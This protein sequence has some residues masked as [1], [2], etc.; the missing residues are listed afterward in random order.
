M[1]ALIWLALCAFVAVTRADDRRW[2]PLLAFKKSI[3]NPSSET[4]IIAGADGAK[5][6]SGKPGRPGPKG[7]KGNKAKFCLHKACKIPNLMMIGFEKIYDDVELMKKTL[8]RLDELDTKTVTKEEL[9]KIIVDQNKKIVDDHD[10]INKL[11]KEIEKLKDKLKHSGGTLKIIDELKKKIK[12]QIKITKEKDKKIKELNHKCLMINN[13]MKENKHLKKKI[14]TLKDEIR[15][16][17]KLLKETG[18]SVKSLKKLHKMV[19]DLHKK[20][21]QKTNKLNDEIQRLKNKLRAKGYKN[22][23]LTAQLKNLEARLHR[24]RK[25]CN[26][27]NK[28]NHKLVGKYNKLVTTCNKNSHKQFKIMQKLHN[29]FYALKR[30]CQNINYFKKR[31]QNLEAKIKQLVNKNNGKK[32]KFS[33]TSVLCSGNSHKPITSVPLN[34]IKYFNKYKKGNIELP[35]ATAT[36]GTPNWIVLLNRKDGSVNFHRNFHDYVTGFGNQNGEFWLGLRAANILTSAHHFKLRVELED[37]KGRKYYANYKKFR[38]GPGNGYRL[39]I[40]GFSGNIYNALRYH[41][42]QRFSTYDKDQDATSRR[43]CAIHN[44]G[45]WYKRCHY[46]V[47]TGHWHAKWMNDKNGLRW[48]ARRRSHM[49]NSY[50]SWKKARML[51]KPVYT[52]G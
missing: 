23:Q 11:D 28:R 32:P 25:T 42:N 52:H 9:I 6:L 7:P 10:I 22:G 35:C 1:K 44:G 16:L 46:T 49:Y 2:C 21:K 45:W 37:H 5:G 18:N 30:K 20:L 48:R 31:I 47:L 24:A 34:K 50:Y 12:E 29:Q 43:N 8:D 15:R 4:F 38:I 19:R 33:K 26:D 27:I 17:G 51:I 40:S 13:A 41:R 3:C 14:N 39:R 36:D